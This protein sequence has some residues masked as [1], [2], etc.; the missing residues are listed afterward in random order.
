MKE[1]SIYYYDHN[2]F[3]KL[4]GVI[5]VNASMTKDEIIKYLVN[6]ESYPSNI[7]IIETNTNC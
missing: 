6:E 7:F 1:Y 5:N 2:N 3:R 4:L